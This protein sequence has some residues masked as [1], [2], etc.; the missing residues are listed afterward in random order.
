MI[1]DLPSLR[2]T[3]E[4]Y[5]LWAEKKFGQHFLFDLNLTRRIAQSAGNLENHTIFEIGPGPG[6]LTRALLE[7]NAK[8]VIAIEL[9]QR[10]IVALEE[11]QERDKRLE[12]IKGDALKTDLVELA[13]APRAV[14]ANLPYN[15]GTALLVQWLHQS[16]EFSSLTLLFQKEVVDRL[17]AKPSSKNYGRLSVL[18]QYC[19]QVRRL[20]DIPPRAFTPPP[21]VVSSL[22]QLIPFQRPVSEIVDIIALGKVTESAFGQRRKMLR[23]ALKTLVQNPEELLQK[24]DIEPTARAEELSVEDFVRL[25]KIFVSQTH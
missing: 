10:C 14:I 13:A 21:K 20:F 3:V 11:L 2:E 25:T 22:V 9:D 5:G 23:A 19:C 4:Q 15:V 12:I 17:V 18:A 24:A 6:G 8:R 7:T 16:K 1:N